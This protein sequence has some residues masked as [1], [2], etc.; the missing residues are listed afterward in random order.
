MPSVC[1]S[2]L[3]FTSS[4]LYATNSLH[5]ASVEKQTNLTRA[6]TLS[7]ANQPFAFTKKKDG[8]D[9]AFNEDA[10]VSQNGVVTDA[11]RTKPYVPVFTKHKSTC[12]HSKK[13]RFL[14]EGEE[15]R[16]AKPLV[17]CFKKSASE[18]KVSLNDLKISSSGLVKVVGGD[19]SNIAK[20]GS[21][22]STV[23]SPGSSNMVASRDRLNLSLNKTGTILGGSPQ[24]AQQMLDSPVIAEKNTQSLVEQNQS[25]KKVRAC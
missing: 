8:I 5:L 23:G 17:P 16:K 24:N 4:T 19:G 22:K 2:P 7:K 10:G 3:T 14:E 9:N 15:L 20:T 12:E 18:S 25:V 11:P 21:A 13:K 6:Q 1:G